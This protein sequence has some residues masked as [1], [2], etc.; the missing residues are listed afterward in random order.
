MRK[1]FISILLA[2]GLVAVMGSCTQSATNEHAEGTET[3]QVEAKPT[4]ERTTVTTSKGTYNIKM[5]M[6]RMYKE[7]FSKGKSQK[8]VHD[9]SPKLNPKTKLHQL[10]EVSFKDDWKVYYGEPN[11]EVAKAVYEKA[12]EK[13]LQGWGDGWGVYSTT[14][15]SIE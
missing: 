14:I 6:K 9:K 7:G 11:N 12:L 2:V 4:F 5:M 3:E 1:I 10:A 13:Y 8:S 15:D